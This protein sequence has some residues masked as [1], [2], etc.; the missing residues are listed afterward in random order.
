VEHSPGLLTD[1]VAEALAGHR[2][3]SAWLG[4]GNALFLGF[5][6]EPIPPRD[7][8]GRRTMPPYE[9]QTSMAGWR[10]GG[11]ASADSDGE[12]GPGE[13][14]V[15]ALVGRPVVRWRLNDRRGVEIEFAG[16]WLLEVVPPAE[17]EP[18]WSDLDEWW[19][20][21][22]G[23]RFVGVSSGGR[24]IAGRTDRVGG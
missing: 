7:P 4:Y 15:A 21:L 16:G 5:G 23:S 14:A 17:V 20:C 22:P 18:D 10:V 1:A 3:V 19:F 12:R 2:C 24:V 9:L 11:D 6:S 8:E 13:R